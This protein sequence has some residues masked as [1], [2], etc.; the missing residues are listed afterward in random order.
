MIQHN[1]PTV[2][3][4][5]AEEAKRI[6]LSASLAQG[7]EVEKFENELCRYLGYEE[8]QA[9]AVSSGTAA[10]YMAIR[11][12]CKDKAV[13]SV[14]I[15]GYSC[16]AL[17][18]AVLFAQ[19]KPC[20]IDVS[21][22]TPILDLNQIDKGGRT[23]VCQMYGTASRIEDRNII[24]DCAQSLGAEVDGKKAGTQT[25]ISVF[26][27]YATKPITSGGEGGAIVSPVKDIIDFVRDL[28]EFDMKSDD[29]SRFNFQM[30][31]LQAAIGRVQLR[32]LDRFIEKRHYL[33]DR[34]ENNG[35]KLWNRQKGGIDYRAI[36]KTE[37][38]EE[39]IRFLA[40][41]EIKAIIPIETSEL[42]CQPK[43]IPNAY[44][45]TRTLVS[46][47]IYPTL[48]DDEQDRIIDAIHEFR[49]S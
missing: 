27:F 35:I 48:K 7:R 4:E 18:N 26:S 45:L 29:V 33:G 36:I 30:T 6:L 40:E 11:A 32:K 24:E 42:L 17:K 5:E 28:R 49:R 8:G 14:N 3:E 19:M 20:V 47:P 1:R 10:L 37:R 34:Y 43:K 25:D 38:P 46:I 21:A 22:D 16:A 9:V 2:G 44:E 15:P 12:A 31:D 23:I 13:D 41:R 39:M